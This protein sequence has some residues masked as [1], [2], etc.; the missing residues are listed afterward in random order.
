MTNNL[1]QLSKELKAFAKKCKDF[2]YTESALFSFLLTGMV[3]LAN[4]V[5][6]KDKEIKEQRQEINTSIGEIKQE[7]KRAKIEN[8]K[9]MKD[10]NLELIKLMEQGDHVVKSPWSSWQFGINTFAGKWGGSY[11]GRGDKK[12]DVIYSR[13]SKLSKDF[14][15]RTSTYGSTTLSHLTEPVTY[16]PVEIAINPKIINK[17]KI[18]VNL[19]NIQTPQKPRLNV[20]IDPISDVTIP[21]VTAPNK[22]VSIVEP[23]AK[24][25]SDFGWSWM[26][27]GKLFQTGYGFVNYN[28][29]DANG[30]DNSTK[31]PDNSGYGYQ[32]YTNWS[33]YAIAENV[34][35]TNGTFWSGVDTSGNVGASATSIAGYDGATYDH[36]LPYSIANNPFSQI[37]SLFNGE[38]HDYKYRHQSILNLHAGPWNN[39]PGFTVKNATFY[40]AGNHGDVNDKDFVLDKKGSGQGLGTEAIHIVGNADLDHITAY[41][42]GKSAFINNETFRGGKTNITNSN[43][44]VKKDEN[45][46]FNLR[47]EFGPWQ[48][49]PYY[50]GDNPTDY[51]GWQLSTK[52]NANVDLTVDHQNNTMYAVKGFAGGLRVDSSGNSSFNGAS[53]IGYSMLGWVPNKYNYINDTYTI[54]TGQSFDTKHTSGVLDRE[55]EANRKDYIPYVK[56]QNAL[57]MYGD[58]NVGIFFNKMDM[59]NNGMEQ[60]FDVGIHQGEF[61]L[62]FKIGEQLNSNGTATTQNTK[63]NLSAKGYS[64]KDV[65][66]NVAVF[67]RSGQRTGV[68][69]KGLYQENATKHGYN[70][71]FFEKDQI[72]DLTFRNFDITFGKHSKNGFMFLAQNG[73]VVDIRN[74]AGTKFTTPQT[75]FSDNSSALTNDENAGLGTV[76]AYSEGVWTHAGTELTEKSG[77]N[78]EGKP[79]EI[80]VGQDLNMAS[81]EGI[82]YM[83]Q[84]GGKVTVNGTTKATGRASIIGYADGKNGNTASE[85]TISK[86]VTATDDGV[87]ANV[88]KFKNIGG[89]AKNGGKVN[90][91]GKATINGIGGF[92]N[93]TGSE[94]TLGANNNDIKAGVQTGLAAI[95]N[96]VVNF[97]G[98]TIEVKDNVS[99]DHAASTP[100][101]AD[102]TGKVV[103]TGDTT[104]NMYNGILVSG[105]KNDYSKNTGGSERYQGMG[106]VTAE[107]KA[108]GVNL[109]NYDGI[110]ATWDGNPTTYL[111]T[112]NTIPQFKAIHDNGKSYTSTLTNGKLDVTQGTVG[113]DD[114]SNNF[115]N[116]SIA[117]E[118]VTISGGTTVTSANGKGLSMGSLSGATSN[119]VTGATGNGMTKYINDGTVNI[120]GGTTTAGAAG[121]NISYGTIENNNKV[122]VDNGAGLYA[123]NGS[124]IVNASTGTINVTGSGVG[125]AALGTDSNAKKNYGTDTKNASNISEKT[126]EI[127]NNGT[128]NV[129]GNDAIAIYAENNTGAARNLVTVDNT[130]KLAVGTNGVG[131]ALVATT[132]STATGAVNHGATRNGGIINA[133]TTGTGSDIVTGVNGKGIYAENSNI[134]LNGGNYAIETL[135]NGVGIF[136]EGDSTVTGTLDYKYNGANNATGVGI[137]YDLA[138]ATNSA[139]NS[140][141]I[142]LTNSTMTTAGL[143]GFYTTATTGTLTNTGNITSTT[144]AASEKEFGIASR[145][146]NI[147]N[148]GNITLGESTSQSVANVGIYNAGDSVVNSGNVTVGKNSIGIYG[149]GV[150]LANS[151]TINAGENGIGIYAEGTASTPVTVDGTINVGDKQAVAIYAIGN[152]QNIETTANSNL[153][154]GEGSFG[155]I[156]AGT[157][158]TITSR[159]SNVGLKKDSVYIYQNDH[160]GSVYNYTNLSSVAGT[161]SPDEIYGIYGNG[162]I[163]NRG[164]IDFSNG[165]GNVGIYSTAGTAKNYGVINVS[166]SNIVNKQ[167]GIGMAT[168]YYNDVTKT[169][170]N[171]GTIE[172]YGTINVSQPNSFGMYATGTGSKAV[173]YGNINLS[174]NDTIGMFIDQGATG[175]NW[176]NITTT[177]SGFTKVK[178][179]YVANGGIVKNYG[180][181]RIDSTDKQSA[182]IWAADGKTADNVEELATGTNPSTGVHQIGTSTPK[183]VVAA[184]TDEKTLGGVTIKT[185][186]KATP[187][188]ITI[189]KTGEIMSVVNVDTDV[190]S[191]TPSKVTITDLSKGTVNVLD[192]TSYNYSSVP[193]STQA[194]SIGMYVDTSGINYT[195]PIQGL[196]NLSGLTDVELIFGTEATKYTNSKAIEVGDN[197]L[198]PYNNALASV[199]SPG[200]TTLNAYSGSLTW[201]AQPV[202]SV[203]TGLLDT[204]YLVKV[205]YTGF[206]R[207]G[208]K[209]T[210]NFLDGLEQRYGVEALG[211]RERAVFTK[212]NDL[213][214]AET[215][216]FTQ[217]VDEMKGHQYANTQRRIFETGNTLD[218]EFKYLHDEWRNPSKQNNKVKIFGMRNEYKTDTA[219]IVD[220]TSDAY[221]IAYVH[222]DETVKLG[223]SSGWYAGAV[224][225]RFKFKDLGKSREN[226]TM[227]KAGVFKT[228][229]PYNDHNGAL[230]WTVAGDAFVGLNEMK[231]RFFVVDDV[232]NAKGDYTSYGAAFKTDLGYDI[233]MSERTHL[234]P[235]GALKME[236]GRFSKIK[237]DSG[238]IRLEVDGNDY[239]S[240]KPEVGLQFK[241]IQPMAVRTQSSV[242]LTAAYEKELGKLDDVNN[243]AR[244]RYTTADWYSLGGEKEDRKGNG[245]FDL[246]IGIDNT[247][248]GVTV[249]AGYDTKGENVR[250]GIGFRAIY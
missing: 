99:G 8:D 236:Y 78:I 13:V 69:V 2:S 45:T 53:N 224:N 40:V 41:L 48:D 4:T 114:S 62:K 148:S 98:G 140:A 20:V 121:I 96:G 233:R 171:Q 118:Q 191:P 229:S 55:G 176:G 234:K 30:N 47:T 155:F 43:V 246:N 190:A 44:Y 136:A 169:S 92:A 54:A 222:E 97:G 25:F 86:A 35:L 84:N 94:V 167:Y 183:M 179:I 156:D 63:G 206:A 76:I 7:F 10:Y 227:L 1:K 90:I 33:Q 110:S 11:K 161:N 205:P 181:I 248:F 100:F 157:G 108:D 247:R 83:A 111:N 245:K 15:D 163:E 139:T 209:D 158:N 81:R 195:N 153:S 243:K 198:T 32:G 73:T 166:G 116:I 217:A 164:N 185:P 202:K 101:Y 228:M 128:I 189:D 131:I 193:S 125:I 237:E 231:R 21:T 221:G 138:N 34:N 199:I 230:R 218:K 242:G 225:N 184:S 126:V 130:S 172:N 112:I 137:V 85:I 95:N 49:S 31:L 154:I 214:N 17:P 75:S 16:I 80:K 226:Q 145:G 212:L 151:G 194:T 188:S 241:Y 82:A 103:I 50:A 216:I 203:A 19:P 178:G 213:G 129:A 113:L 109:G 235:Y 180:T 240:V 207:K 28:F 175:E 192:A 51:R 36:S 58:E 220:Y 24:P 102:S 9:L 117:N 42:Y 186:P 124:K 210:Y 6:T 66:G 27:G 197:I 52:F 37:S 196:N 88:N 91:Q 211:S 119:A 244:V 177:A 152:G 165:V 150:T 174:G 239:F 72:H 68:D 87:T 133:T 93:G 182:G 23:N 3:S 60:H 141:N 56:M 204:L 46:I 106:K 149:K 77:A 57:N 135:D 71:S 208:D 5:I 143:V 26:N 170:S 142:N 200:G 146:A 12:G 38:R 120:T 219:G 173:N 89:Y 14:P 122:S 64:D 29:K 79:T 223:N 232:F 39:Q 238:E 74:D 22:T 67:A 104:V 187:V 144:T 132:P 159:T 127:V 59:S 123:T 162:Y 107:I 215:H 147:V 249:N 134:N 168:G 105:T 65:D 160:T 201:L 70:G 18:N 115:N 61:D 250:G